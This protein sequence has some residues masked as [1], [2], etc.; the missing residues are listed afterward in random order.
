MVASK[1][2]DKL[3]DV[4][5]IRE[6][7]P[8]GR[9]HFR[10]PPNRKSSAKPLPS[11][12]PECFAE[13]WK[14]R[15]SNNPAD[16][17]QRATL[18]AVA[19]TISQDAFSLT[20]Q[21]AAA[22]YLAALVMS[23]QRLVAT[24]KPVHNNSEQPEKERPTSKK[25]RKRQRKQELAAEDAVKDMALADVLEA[26][27]R[28]RDGSAPMN[29]TESND[30]EDVADG[31]D[32]IDDDVELVGSL[33]YLIGLTVH[34]TSQAIL[35]AKCDNILE[36]T[37]SAHDHTFGHGSVSRHTSAVFTGVLAVIDSI[38]W[39][40]PVVQR[41]YLYLL[42]ST[43][44]G[45]P[46]S[47]RKA[48]EALSALLHSPRANIVRAKSSAA[49]SAHFVSELK[50]HADALNET[51]SGDT[52]AEGNV[53][54]TMLV[55][56]LTS[57]E[58]FAG[59]LNPQDAAKVAKELLGISVKELPNISAFALMA[60]NSLFKGRVQN[61]TNGTQ[62]DDG[63]LLPRADLDKLLKAALRHEVSPDF[64]AEAIIAYNT[65]IANGTVAYASSFA[66]ALPPSEV[67][68]QSV[69]KLCNSI[70]PRDTR[71]EV[72][73]RTVTELQGLLAQRWLKCRPEILTELHE[74]T[75]PSYRVIWSDL[76][77]IF[78]R[79]LRDDM[80]AG[81]FQLRN[82]VLRLARTVATLR[83]KALEAKDRKAQDLAMAITSS[84]VCGGGAERFLHACEIRY[85]EKLHITNAWLLPVLRDGLCHAPLSVFGSKLLPVA[86][87]L[88]EAMTNAA[89]ESRSVEAKNIGI[90][91]SQI[92]GLLPGFCHKPSD[93][94][95]DGILTM[96]FQAIHLCLQAEDRAVMYPI[97]AA[98]LGQISLSV[99]SLNPD[100]RTTKGS[101]ESFN[102]RF[103][104]LFPTI[105]AVSAQT[106]DD[107]RGLLLDALSKACVATKDPSLVTN[108]LRKSIRRLLELQLK[109][110]QQQKEA[111]ETMEEDNEDLV[112]EQHAAA[113][114]A[115]AIIGS[116]AIPH[117]A[118]EITFLEKA[119]S[120][121]FLDA[122][123]SSLQKKAYRATAQLVSV[124]A[125][126]KSHAELQTFSKNIAD[127]AKHVAPGAKAARQ[128][129]VTALVNRHL[130]ITN[131]HE[132]AQLL[133]FMNETFLS[134]VILGTRDTS[135]KTRSASYDTLIS[136]ARGWNVLSEGA[137]M[138]G[139]RNFFIAVAA[140]LGGKTVP[141][142]SATLTS[143]GRLMYEFRGEAHVNTKLAATIDALFGSTAS[144][145]EEDTHMTSDVKEDENKKQGL[146][147]AGPV[148]ILLRHNAYEVQKSALGV[149]KIATTVLAA[150]ERRLISVLPGILPGLIH[151]SARSKK[152]ETRL[153]VR[154]IL[155]RLL[156]RC[157]RDALEANFPEEHVK[158]LSTVR[159]KYSRDLIKKHA[160]KDKRRRKSITGNVAEQR[161]QDSDEGNDDEESGIDNSDSDVEREIVDGDDL[162]ES[163]NRERARESREALRVKEGKGQVMDLL[164]TKNSQSV[165]TGDDVREASRRARFEQKRKTSHTNDGIR[166][167]DDGRPILVESDDDSREAEVGSANSDDENSD[168]DTTVLKSAEGPL[169]RKRHRQ[170]FQDNGRHNKRVKGSFGEEYRSRRGA[171][172]VKRV[173]RPNPYAYIPLGAGMLGSKPRSGFMGGKSRQDSSLERLRA[174]RDKR[175]DIRVGIPARR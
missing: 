113:D 114:V 111:S 39:S 88:K 167:T 68:L 64:P 152:Q 48:R 98:A 105:A 56:L 92:W 109:R 144:N 127:T 103:R 42:R 149:I 20:G 41:A 54:P 130:R 131:K 147:Q 107:R 97:A 161:F 96:A 83:E 81:S 63:I 57:V 86:E 10:R 53:D 142:L 6:A 12:L 60:L 145:D 155:E 158:L 11:S 16:R 94:S 22:V 89:S 33:V 126:I 151:V 124:G 148:A 52:T 58:R 93:L 21:S 132:K 2:G 46:K 166:Y 73:R 102:T 19:S 135:E 87:K 137:N 153:R 160:A 168:S 34:G 123:H 74:F 65:C 122:K 79:Y 28:E 116:N 104:K 156:R 24:T 51:L 40:K 66:H 172:D 115:I 120:P 13:V 134:E 101:I 77:P 118:T 45:D 17:R 25:E 133:E 30:M 162:M 70:D 5:K 18:E 82:E 117:D 174:R 29:V 100:D 150:P 154:V 36:V 141:M 7:L 8:S 91:H 47:R 62:G 173:G 136:M 55:H 140:G 80:A 119:M 90:Y 38:S 143:L 85:D 108:L 106:P 112:R 31:N 69:R 110:S 99:S 175:K 163:G 44:D 171:G 43:S 32:G 138:S 159:K 71:R 170:D 3:M 165:L 9:S 23:L 4:G 95:Q 157:G 146:V 139:L 67:I 76:S 50:L 49:A 72:I 14:R 121:F 1:S 15:R 169:G 78:N 61:N 125:V 84:I 128:N 164:D 27:K 35:N 129:L 75:S 37:M 26:S 59:F